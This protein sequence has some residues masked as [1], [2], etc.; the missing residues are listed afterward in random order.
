MFRPRPTAGRPG[1]RASEPDLPGP[2][3]S[4]RGMPGAVKAAVVVMTLSL[5]TGI[6]WLIVR[7]PLP[8]A[9]IPLLGYMDRPAPTPPPTT[10][11]AA[12]PPSAEPAAP[13]PA[14][15][16]AEPPSQ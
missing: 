3:L 16:P 4:W 11:P 12:P 10:T 1:P 15:P 6:V 9:A 2:R 8:A 13:P 14:E 5:L 7:P